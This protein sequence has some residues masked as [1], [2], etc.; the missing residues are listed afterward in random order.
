MNAVKQ[1]LS[2]TKKIMFANDAARFVIL[3]ASCFQS[4]AIDADEIGLD[5]LNYCLLYTSDA[6]DE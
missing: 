1:T 6:A 5:S 3:C 2:D 4:A